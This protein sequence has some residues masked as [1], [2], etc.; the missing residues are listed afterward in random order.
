ME[1]NAVPSVNP[2]TTLR[3][4][5]VL[6][7]SLIIAIFGVGLLWAEPRIFPA[8]SHQTLLVDIASTGM[9]IAG[10]LAIP[11]GIGL[12]IQ[13]LRLLQRSASDEEAARVRLRQAERELTELLQRGSQT[14]GGRSTNLEDRS[15]QVTQDRLTLPALWKVTHSRL[16][17]YHQIAT[18]QARRSFITAQI[19]IGVGFGMLIVFAVIA[20]QIH[21]T[22]SA[23]A[24]G[25][26]GAVSGALAGYIGRTFVRSQESAAAHL[27][28]YFDQ[29]LE[30]SRYLAAERLL[31][32]N[33]N[34][35]EDQQAA[36]LTA[37]VQVI[38]T[39]NPP[40]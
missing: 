16:D 24:A 33:A 32:S 1:P 28:A 2:P 21:T 23:I 5:R 8:S 37:L 3:D 40:T 34:L 12:F 26:L 15:E 35:S 6:V 22:A 31:G 17:L 38:A 11:A 13:C 39:S 7:I 25:A 19:A 30:F 27:R 14:A 4:A 36:I 29:P 18:G 9:A 10:S 20:T